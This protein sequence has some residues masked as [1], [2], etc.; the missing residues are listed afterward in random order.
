MRPVLLAVAAKFAQKETAQAFQFLISLGVR[1]LIASTTRS[2]SV[3]Q[4]LSFAA[5]E[6]FT[7][8]ITTPADLKKRLIE[9]W[10]VKKIQDGP[11]R[12]AA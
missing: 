4:P 5:N 1:L 9:I 10:R 8:K 6:I 7:G 2:G 12:R 3:E 11:V